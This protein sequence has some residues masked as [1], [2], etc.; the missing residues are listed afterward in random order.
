MTQQYPRFGYRR[1][2]I[3]VSLGETRVHRLWR[4]MRLQL[5]RKRPRR[6]RTGSDIR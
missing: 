4:N 2:A 3:W 6:P 1:A 5:P